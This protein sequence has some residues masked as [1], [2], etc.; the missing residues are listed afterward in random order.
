M[1]RYK[2][3][4]RVGDKEVVEEMSCEVGDVDFY[5]EWLLV[6]LRGKDDENVEF[7]GV[8]LAQG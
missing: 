2:Y 4:F 6:L 3:T 7:K 5:K 1:N 8:Q